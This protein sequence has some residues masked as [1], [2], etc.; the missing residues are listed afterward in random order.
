MT[1]DTILLYP[2]AAAI[3]ASVAAWTDTRTR[4]IPN[5]LT[6]PSLLLALLLHGM[7]DGWRGLLSSL[8]ACL[9]AGILFLVFHLAGGMGAGDV[10]GI[11]AVAALAG[12]PNTTILLVYTSLAGGV[13]AIALA[14]MKG[15]LR[16]TLG[17]VATLMQHHGTQGMVPHEEFNVR[18]TNT[19]RLPYGV[20]IAAGA[21]LT[22]FGAGGQR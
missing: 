11:A 19:L 15:R 8:A 7:L 1:I 17:N 2:A 20:A 14:M 9:T 16:Q 6:G 5:W 21:L 22:L 18:N 12:L 4:R 10:K 13:M 3:S